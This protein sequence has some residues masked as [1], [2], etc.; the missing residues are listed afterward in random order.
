[1]R[2]LLSLAL[3]LTAACS[4]HA[5]YQL[6]TLVSYS[7][8]PGVV[9]TKIREASGPNFIHILE[10][11]LNNP[12]IKMQTVKAKN[13]KVGLEKPSVMAA[14]QEA[15]GH[16]VIGIVNADFFVNNAPDNM[17]VIKGEITRKQRSGYAAVGFD[18]SNHYMLSYPAFKGAIVTKGAS[19][20][21]DDVD[22]LRVANQMVIYNKY[23]GTMTPISGT[24]TEAVLTPID[25]WFVN[26]TVHCI[27][28]SVGETTG[29]TPIG[30]GQM[31][32]SAAGTRA[33]LL[34]ANVKAGDTVGVAIDVS[35]GPRKVKELV[36]GRPIFFKL[37]KVDS[38]VASISVVAVRNPRTLVGFSQDSTKCYI[39]IIDGRQTVSV[40]MDI[41]EM[42]ALMAQL[43]VYHAMNFD[44]GGSAIMLVNH[45][46]VNTPS[47]G[48]ERSVSN[49]LMIVSSEPPTGATSLTIAPS[50][51][52][53]FRGGMYQFALT[54]RDTYRSRLSLT[55]AAYSF[56]CDRRIGTVT[57]EGVFTASNAPD[58]GYVYVR[59]QS[60]VD[61]A[62]VRIIDIK[63]FSLVSK[64]PV[65]GVVR[66]FQ[67]KIDAYDA[68]GI[69]QNML[70][71]DIAWRST[72]P[73]VGTVDSAG[74]F[75]GLKNGRT[76]VIATYHELADTAV[77]TVEAGSGTVVLDAMDS[78][79]GWTITSEHVD[80]VSVTAVAAP[81][82][83]GTVSLKIAYSYTYDP[84]VT[85]MI[86]LAKP[87]RIF[88]TPDTVWLDARTNGLKHRLYY[89]L[90]DDNAELFR[91]MGR[92]Y[93]EDSTALN[94][95]PGPL[96]GLQILTAGGV[97]NFPVT[98]TRIELQ[99]GAGQSAGQVMTGA[100]YLDNLRAKYPDIPT[101]VA[102]GAHMPTAFALEQN[103]P[104]PF[105][106][107][108]TVGYSLRMRS[109]VTLAIYNVL[110]QRV[111][112]LVNAEQPAG[113]YRVPWTAG[114]ASGMYFY[115][116]EAVGEN[117]PANRYVDVKKMILMR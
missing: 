39:F 98:L 52:K 116:I 31:V 101:S 106:P 1:M 54:A 117:D 29:G 89:Q 75:M 114:V 85:S 49:G 58:S 34:N 55:A 69:K 102:A 83:Q 82:S 59:H 48:S 61:S 53:I 35:A 111:A 18:T 44:G 77:V 110:G 9:Y 28:T 38:S 68:D 86:Y 4:L 88:G 103:Y 40:G 24:G 16:H 5:Q 62:F 94:P 42:S 80:S 104:N 90:S 36:G 96:T 27:V 60:L 93:L 17:Q 41:W 115:R 12:F 67:F 33:V 66:S 70:L 10:T 56:S 47:D 50:V 13:L 72:D 21:I 99:L 108:T 92:K 79:T 95:I 100:I 20:T 91:M 57:A 19:I 3:L 73:S 23:F 97:F 109:R 51:L 112:E 78:P 65:A 107:S 105:N 63:Q 46:T 64:A 45:E 14:Q 26:D 22:E 30:N 11:D 8:G 25:E 84:A 32:L 76:T 15:P 71:T 37:G 81:A 87:I 113:V 7:A 43:K 6:D 2:S 74:L